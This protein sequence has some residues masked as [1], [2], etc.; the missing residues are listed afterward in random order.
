MAVSRDQ[1]DFKA[2]VLRVDFQ[3]A[4]DGETE[5]GKDSALQRWHIKARDEEE[6]GRVVPLPPNVAFELRRHIKNHGVWGPERLLF[7]NVRIAAAVRGRPPRT[8][9]PTGWGANGPWR[10][11]RGRCVCA[12][13]R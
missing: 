6:P 9:W 2:E 8:T 4:E 13:E 7:P 10:S 5:S 12:G 3:I 1:I 11:A